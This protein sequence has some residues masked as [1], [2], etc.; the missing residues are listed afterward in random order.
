M[1]LATWQQIAE[2]SVAATITD[3]C[4]LQRCEFEF[5]I[6]VGLSYLQISVNNCR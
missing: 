2:M 6:P 5:H 3:I 4:K 1:G